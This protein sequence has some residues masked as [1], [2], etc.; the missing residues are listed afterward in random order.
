MS[1]IF[2]HKRVCSFMH[3]RFSLREKQK[4]VLKVVAFGREM[5]KWYTFLDT[6]II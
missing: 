1:K 4:K 2:K 3:K 6:H 5:S